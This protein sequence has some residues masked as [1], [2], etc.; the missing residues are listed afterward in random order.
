MARSLK[1]IHVIGGGLA[2]AEAAWQIARGACRLCCTKCG[3]CARP[4]CTR[5]QTSPSSSARTRSA[6]TMRSNAVGLLHGEM[7]RLGFA[8][9]AAADDHQAAGGRRAGR[10]PR[11]LCRRITAALER[12]PLVDIRARGSRG[13]P[14]P[15]WD[16]VI[17]ATGPLTSPALAEAISGLTGRR[18]ARLLRRHRADRPPRVDRLR[19]RLVSVALRQ[20]GTR[21]APAPIT[22][23]AR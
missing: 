11:W 4:P 13:L 6:P 22:S 1:P 15:E 5:R 10:R 19:R 3:P 9:H 20:G 23:I 17:V 12:E 14:P 21:A 18:R 8:D 2:G 16:S 7:R